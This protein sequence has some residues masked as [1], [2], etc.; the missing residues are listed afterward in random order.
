[1]IDYCLYEQVLEQVL[2]TEAQ[3]MRTNGKR[4][5]LGLNWR[6][7]QSGR[8]SRLP[9]LVGLAALARSTPCSTSLALKSM[10]PMLYLTAPNQYNLRPK[11]A[12]A[13]TFPAWDACSERQHCPMGISIDQS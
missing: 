13:Y 9:T 8:P 6:P 1:M 5:S 3:G 4:G 7:A 12:C 2:R 11:Q 10:P